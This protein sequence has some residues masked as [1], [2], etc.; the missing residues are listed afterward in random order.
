MLV[1]GKRDVQ[2][3]GERVNA[4][5]GQTCF[6]FAWPSLQL[7]REDSMKARSLVFSLLLGLSACGTDGNETDEHRSALTA[8][9]LD[10]ATVEADAELGACEPEDPQRTTI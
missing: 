10:D 8:S 3:P 7:R 1:A 6:P 4:D 5:S 2:T 9:G